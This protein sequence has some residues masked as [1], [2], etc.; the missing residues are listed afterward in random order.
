MA[1]IVIYTAK[2]CSYCRRA[3]RLL[4]YKGIGFTEIDVTFNPAR[5][6]E[7]AERA[8]GGWTVPQIFIDGRAIGAG[9]TGA[10]LAGAIGKRFTC[11]RTYLVAETR[12]ILRS[13]HLTST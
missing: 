8:G 5:R 12:S 10:A 7:M 4:R 13:V 11:R 9:R 2:L 6:A 3:R 1:E